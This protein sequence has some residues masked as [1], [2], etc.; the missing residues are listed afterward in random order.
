M[1]ARPGAALGVQ[2][3]VNRARSAARVGDLGEA[4]RLLDE[5][6]TTS[7]S[8]VVLDLRA[9]VHAQRGELTEADRCWARVQAMAPDDAD[10]AY[11]RRTIERIIA[12][13]RLARPIVTTT[14]VAVAAAGAVL[15]VL[16][17][18][19][20]WLGSAEHS[21]TAAPMVDSARLQAEIQRVQ[22]LQDRLAALDADR[23][24]A[25]DRLARNL[26][27]I[28]KRMEMPGV[29]VRPSTDHIQLIFETG[30]FRSGAAITREGAAQLTELGSR[31]AGMHVRTTVVG[32]AVA[33]P[34]GRTS[35]GSTVALAR[36]QVAAERLASGGKLPLT[37]FN[38]ASAEQADGPFPDAPRNR[39][40][41]LV[42]IPEVP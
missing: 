4:A 8:V 5:L 9:R 14:R 42:I 34:G 12:G 36:A 23:A 29:L 17:G 28:A 10:A 39:T 32:H 35:G 20:V 16:V 24:A 33:V 19:A 21:E 40:V 1:S 38:L 6:D 41:T 30:L 22:A 7:R 15:V 27:A 13:R 31:L 26:D 37:A 3:A 18:G 2:L 25:A 11:G